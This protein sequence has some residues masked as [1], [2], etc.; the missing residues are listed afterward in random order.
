MNKEL[1]EY[2]ALDLINKYDKLDVALELELSMD[3]SGELGKEIHKDYID[4]MNAIE[5]ELK[6]RGLWNIRCSKEDYFDDD[7]PF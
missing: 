4:E 7:L 5:E 6:R 2:T 1:S 3:G